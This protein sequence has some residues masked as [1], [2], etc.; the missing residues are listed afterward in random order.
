MGRVRG[1]AITENGRGIAA[2]L[3]TAYAVTG[4]TG[5]SEG[6]RQR[7]SAVM[8]GADGTFRLEHNLGSGSES[9]SVMRWDL[10]VTVETRTDKSDGTGAR[11]NVLASETR[12]DASGL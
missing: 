9:A 3:V 12:E 6:R 8:T 5:G 1:Q 10:L 4:N 2:L 7:L 11:R